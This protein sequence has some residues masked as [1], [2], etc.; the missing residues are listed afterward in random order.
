M[1]GK[2]LFARFCERVSIEKA[3]AEEAEKKSGNHAHLAM[4]TIYHR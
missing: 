4:S 2:K 3:Y 1:K